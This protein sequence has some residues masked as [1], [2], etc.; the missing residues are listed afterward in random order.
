MSANG[1]GQLRRRRGTRWCWLFRLVL[2]LF[3][4]LQSRR[5]RTG[6]RSAFFRRHLV[7]VCGRIVAG[8]GRPRQ[9]LQPLVF[10]LMLLVLL[11]R[12]VRLVD[13]RLRETG[14][15][16]SGASIVCGRVRSFWHRRRRAR[17]FGPRNWRRLTKRILGGRDAL[18]S[19]RRR[20]CLGGSGLL[21]LFRRWFFG[22]AHFVGLGRPGRRD[23]FEH[24]RHGRK[25]WSLGGRHRCRRDLGRALLQGSLP[26]V[27][28]LFRGI[29][30]L[31]VVV[32]GELELGF[33]QA[34]RGRVPR[35]LLGL[36]RL[37]ADFAFERHRQSR[38]LFRLEILLDFDVRQLPADVQRRVCLT[39]PLVRRRRRSDASGR[40]YLVL[41]SGGSRSGST[42]RSSSSVST[43]RVTRILPLC[44]SPRS[45][46]RA[47]PQDRGGTRA[48]AC[49]SRAQIRSLV[50]FTIPLGF[51]RS[52]CRRMP[53]VAVPF[54]TIAPRHARHSQTEGVVGSA[55]GRRRRLAAA[56]PLH[57]LATVRP[58]T[59]LPV[60]RELHIVV[61]CA[62][63]VAVVERHGR[64]ISARLA[65]TR[66]RSR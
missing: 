16:N 54:L 19:R 49:P 46:S 50:R 9:R 7:R 57:S 32:L 2:S 12:H 3:F 45:R 25:G 35:L 24:G 28:P 56:P 40:R 31:L 13:V 36:S 60:A 44:S 5:I 63:A 48:R 17:E 39:R 18:R 21:T 11:D 62:V 26:L 61:T 34:R 42:S 64:F 66:R 59:R 10:L 33:A 22:G 43:P 1:S 20:G 53:V 47:G 23:R 27:L 37:I 38:S 55:G 65:G 51:F 29:L 52:A 41:V 30:F 15:G 4:F 14:F 6:R 8:G 58:V